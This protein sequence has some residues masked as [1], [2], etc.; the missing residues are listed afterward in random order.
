MQ[1]KMTTLDEVRAKLD[2]SIPVMYDS[3]TIGLYGKI[4]LAQFYQPHFDMPLLVEYPDPLLLVSLLT[5]QH[6]VGHNIHYDISTIQ[7][8]LGKQ[9][10][11][12]ER[13]DCTFLLSRLYYYLR[14]SFSLDDVVVYA[15]GRDVYAEDLNLSKTEQQKSDW[16]VP[17]LS[18]EQKIYAAADVFYLQQVW[19]IVK[20]ALEDY[21]YK[22][23]L[24]CTRYCLEFQNVGM[25]IDIKRLEERF[26]KNTQEIAELAVPINVNSYQQVRP[27]IGSIMSDGEGLARLAL[28]GNE[29]ADKVNKTRKLI[30]NN[31]FLTKFL[32][33]MNDAVDGFG[34]IYGKFKCSARSGRTTSD[35]QNLQ[36]L[37]RSLKGIFGFEEDGDTVMIYSDF[38][39]IQLRA[40]CA[41]TA[42]R[43]MEK[44]FRDGQ[45]LH[46]FVAAM[47]FGDTFTARERQI[48]KTANFGL[49]FGAGINTFISILIKQANIWLT[50]AQ[51]KEIRD[52]WLKLWVQIAEWQKQGIKDWKKGTPW[53]TVLGRRYTAKMMTDQ[54]AMQIQGFEA[55]VAKLAMHYMLPKL[56]ELHNDIQLCNFIH[57]SFLFKCP[58]DKEVYTKACLIIADAMQE[59]WV[60]IS[61]NAL[62]TD[63][64]M[65][66]KVRVGFNWGDIEKDIFIHEHVQ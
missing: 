57:D 48:S 1:Y 6:T 2:P 62:I 33:T 45:D 13:F 11:M 29:K 56:K 28:Q 37:P 18:E 17:V 53:E 14:D 47:I 63:L 40:V 25:P 15:T 34:T 66:V 5:K 27:Y 41:Q 35:D 10:W 58:N 7:D 19:D 59:A 3:E 30:K 64:P 24:L 60:Q 61:Q 20:D 44:L 9:F 52:K 12:P 23:D 4:R 46:S 54:L 16:S 39:Q 43:A 49:L 38:A 50:D 51:A 31:S 8:Q 65:P 36:Q 55:E 42:D 26:A 32:N 21:S 22:L